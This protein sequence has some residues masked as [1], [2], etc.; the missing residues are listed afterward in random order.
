M[1]NNDTEKRISKYLKYIKR[2][3]DLYDTI[4]RKRN[5]VLES[6]PRK[7]IKLHTLVF[8]R[9]LY[10]LLVYLRRLKNKFA[11]IEKV[12]KTQDKLR[13]YIGVPVD[14]IRTKGQ[15]KELTLLYSNYTNI[16][17]KNTCPSIEDLIKDLKKICEFAQKYKIEQVYIETYLLK[18]YLSYSLV[19]SFSISSHTLLLNHDDDGLL[20]LLL[21]KVTPK[22]IEKIISE[23]ENSKY[24][25]EFIYSLRNKVKDNEIIKA[26][27]TYSYDNNGSKLMNVAKKRL[28]M[29][30]NSDGTIK[31]RTH[32]KLYESYEIGEAFL[33]KTSFTPDGTLLGK[34]IITLYNYLEVPN[35]SSLERLANK[36]TDNQELHLIALLYLHLIGEE[37]KEERGNVNFTTIYDTIYDNYKKT[38]FYKKIPWIKTRKQKL[39]AE[40]PQHLIAI[41]SFFIGLLISSLARHI[42]NNFLPLKESTLDEYNSFLD[43][44]SNAYEESYELEQNILNKIKQTLESILPDKKVEEI[45][46]YSQEQ[47]TEERKDDKNS[48]IAE[49]EWFTKEKMPVYFI[50]QYARSATYHNGELEFWMTSPQVKLERIHDVRPMFQ[51]KTPIS[52]ER[53]NEIVD[54]DYFLLPLEFY[55]AGDDFVLTRIIIKD[56]SDPTKSYEFNQEWCYAGKTLYDRSSEIEYL[57]TFESPMIYYIYGIDREIKV[58]QINGGTNYSDKYDFDIKEA[59]T[60]GLGI[61]NNATTEEINELIFK[62]DYTK[63]PMLNK[64]EELD[65]LEFYKEIASLDA[66]DIDQIAT[67]TTLANEHSI[68]I[69]GFKNQNDDDIISTDEAYVWVINEDGEIIDFLKNITGNQEPEFRTVD[70]SEW[71]NYEEETKDDFTSYDERKENQEESEITI[72]EKEEKEEEEKII[73]KI[74][75]WA[76]KHHI[77]YYIAALIAILIINKTFGRKIKFKIQVKRA[78]KLLRDEDLAE[79]YAKLMEFIYGRECMPIK[80]D[81]NKMIETITKEFAALSDERINELLIE[82]ESE[83]KTSKQSYALKEVAY[84]LK[85]IPFIRDNKK[86]IMEYNPKRLILGG[87]HEK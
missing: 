48:K 20:C 34:S 56:E 36:K 72:E 40:M 57:S 21:N 19:K 47:I 83:I 51:I 85:N 26:I 63:Y 30:I 33:R 24:D 39:V 62:K 61:D 50:D 16:G 44:I 60:E 59:I 5:A 38:P 18:R 35:Y 28:S 8:S 67:L 76:S 25:N 53:L 77:H 86:T 17:S 46:S 10:L 11:P 43:S 3:G 70:S 27:D 65:E 37:R 9:I 49:I 74:F 15:K 54:A 84:I 22:E 73:K 32:G 31:D 78:D 80:K 29:L 87:R 2:K 12:K 66:L 58:N 14:I 75:S 79:N 71:L 13:E 41:M 68:Y 52:K 81:K 64:K 1:Y 4:A 69:S 82:L 45:L 6:A 42:P 23:L 55:P 7:V